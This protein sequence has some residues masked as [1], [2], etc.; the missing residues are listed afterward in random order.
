MTYTISGNYLAAC[1]CAVVCGCSVDAQPRDPQGGTECLGAAVFHISEGRLDD[2]DLAG[3]DFAFY[4]QFPSHLTAGN[5]KVGLVI[6]SGASDAQ[7]DAV[8]RILSG[9]EGGPFGELAQFIG[10]FLGTERGEVSLTDDDAPGLDVPG[11][12]RVTYEPLLG[13]DGTPTT[14]KN[15]MFGFSAEYGIGKAGGTSSAF[16]LTFEP[17]YG[18]KADF[19]FSSE[20]EAGAPKGR[21]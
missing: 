19:V 15:A 4:N 21:V 5:W 14:V 20:Q 18:E 2:T 16:G 8:G 9:Q 12:S 10:E 11:H 17:V 1:S 13:V 6:D 7:A 3:V